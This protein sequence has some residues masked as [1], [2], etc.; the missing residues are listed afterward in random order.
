M[1][2]NIAVTVIVPTHVQ[3]YVV[4]RADHGTATPA[5]GIERVAGGTYD[6]QGM[7]S[8]G[9][10]SSTE[11]GG[12]VVALPAGFKPFPRSA[13]ESSIAERFASG[14]RR[15]AAR[16]AVLSPHGTLTYAELASAADRVA[17][18]V[19][20]HSRCAARTVVVLCEQRPTLVA[21]ILGVL[22]A[23]RCYVPL[24]PAFPAPRLARTIERVET[25]LIV[26][27]EHTLPLARRL[28]RAGVQVIDADHLPATGPLASPP[29]PGPND[30]A[31]I[32]FTSGSTGEPKGV[33]DCH[34]NVL[35]NVMRYTN[36]LGLDA[37]DRLTLLQRPAFSG[38]VSS[39]FGALLNGG[40][41]CL[42][43]L[44][45][46]GPARLREWL[47]TA[48]VTVYHSVPSIFRA[49]APA[50][51][52][53]PALR[54]VRL[55]GDRAMRLDLELF[56]Q[57]FGDGCVLVNGLGATECGLVRQF[58]FRRGDPLP[59]AGVPIGRAVADM[60]IKVV[61]EQG[62]EVEVGA[63]GEIVVSSEY[64]AL[65]YWNDAANTARRFSGQPGGRRSWRTGDRG[66]VDAA[67]CLE[68][69]GRIEWQP[70][71]RGATV[72]V[73]AI[74]QALLGSGA[75]AQVAVV[76]LASAGSSERL[77]AYVVPAA[78]TAPAPA[79][80]RAAVVSAV[81]AASV[82]TDY[83][84]LDALPLGENGKVDLRRLPPTSP[85]PSPEAVDTSAHAE[86]ERPLAA[87]W[88]SVLRCDSVA[89]DADFRDL[90]GDSLAAADLIAEVR[91]RFRVELPDSVL[92]DA[93][94]VAALAAVIATSPAAGISAAA[95][96]PAGVAWV[97]QGDGA[98]VV[99][100]TGDMLGTGDAPKR[101]ARHLGPGVPL[102]QVAPFDPEID[103][104]P[105]TLEAM[106]A[107]RLQQLAPLLLQ[108]QCHV[109]GYC[110]AGGLLAYELA[111]QLEAGGTQV[112]SVM[113]IDT[114]P[115]LPPGSGP[116]L[117]ASARRAA[118]RVLRAWPAL[119][120]RILRA[121]RLPWFEKRE[122]ERYRASPRAAVYAAHFRARAVYEP[123]PV[124]AALILLWPEGEQYHPSREQF[125]SG[126][127]ALSPSV[128]LV[129]LPGDHQAL[130]G[131]QMPALAGA[132]RQVID[133]MAS[134]AA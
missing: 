71:F 58:G 22:A 27:D 19:H 38:A 92:L 28:A 56:A 133:A 88:A 115:I 11:Q 54:V 103:A 97:Q 91:E 100:A 72:E 59:P 122:V 95:S 93:P 129:A 118:D 45:A 119:R 86:I 32:Y 128:R 83:V 94:T 78:G 50:G 113:L 134:S 124:H 106:A 49:I 10:G 25:D 69:L 39:L 2:K 17:A 9:F 24:D 84:L 26:A 96:L 51:P 57:H 120:R 16:L 65:G 64:L 44:N 33:F 89:R 15:L 76:V 60:D 41:S 66:H 112:L 116:G 131:H 3:P 13:L 104:T 14:A 99:F 98:P 48:G 110:G 81:T 37:S 107:R 68:H 77:V 109:L 61:D 47:A 12:N 20:A 80:L 105:Q 8:H 34:R 4:M 87:I 31:Y 130:I 5:W 102:L 62:R 36:S 30:L 75:A 6:C 117:A 132:I 123:A 40:T 67:G 73:E 35:H 55:E 126:W 79:E 90:G 21:A 82:P 52:T 74:E 29:P 53:L 23:R 111:R 114:F 46:E 125:V 7:I 63:S 18:A 108:R 70:R 121:R 43:D 85:R 101:L 1:H 42:F 127:S